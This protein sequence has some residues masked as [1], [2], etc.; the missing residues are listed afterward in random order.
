MK[1]LVVE[2]EQRIATYLKKGLE[3]QSYIVDLA[4]DGEVGFD[5]ASNE[6]YDVI[7][8]DRMLPKKDGMVVCAELRAEGNHTPVLF[9]TA[10]SQVNDRVEGLNGGADDYL[11]KP[12][13]FA[14]LVARIQ[15]LA[16]RPRVTVGN[17]LQVGSLV[18]DTQAYTV[19]R[20]GVTID[21]SKKEY[22][23]LEFLMRHAG[24][25]FSK[26]QLTEQVWSYESDVLGNTAQVYIGYLRSKIDRP[27]PTEPPLIQTARGFGYRLGAE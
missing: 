20:A 7:V 23:L 1:I 8:L 2:D 21:L 19:L 15:A 27:F 9:L 22:A 17:R 14:E 12:F 3:L 6:E 13:E 11:V 16:R 25:V 24:Q 5:L 4:F 10:K 26:E 18:M